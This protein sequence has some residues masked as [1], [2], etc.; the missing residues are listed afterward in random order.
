MLHSSS[1][2]L[3]LAGRVK[4]N[5]NNETDRLVINNIVETK[6]FETSFLVLNQILLTPSA[7]AIQTHVEN[8]W[9]QCRHMSEILLI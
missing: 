6:P 9:T 3:K 1:Q 2:T 4:L 7:A 8:S 5:L